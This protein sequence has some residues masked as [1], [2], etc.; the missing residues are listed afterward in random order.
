MVEMETHRNPGQEDDQVIVLSD[1]RQFMGNDGAKFSL[2]PGLPIV[3][4]YQNRVPMPHR[5]GAMDFR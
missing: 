2:G 4:Q 5:R 1:M 3:R